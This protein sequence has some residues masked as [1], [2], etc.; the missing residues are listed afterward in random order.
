MLYKNSVNWKKGGG[1]KVVFIEMFIDQ[2]HLHS[3]SSYSR[4]LKKKSMVIESQV[5]KGTE[6]VI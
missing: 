3:N 1:V 4:I 6:E 5:W 2:L